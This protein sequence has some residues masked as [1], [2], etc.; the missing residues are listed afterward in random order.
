MS[1]E[2]R[3]WLSFWDKMIKKVDFLNRTTDY[4]FFIALNL[5]SQFLEI[6][7]WGMG[8][9]LTNFVATF[10]FVFTLGILALS[11]C[12]DIDKAKWVQLNGKTLQV[13]KI[14]LLLRNN[15]SPLCCLRLLRLAS[16]VIRDKGMQSMCATCANGFH[17]CSVRWFY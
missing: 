13:L 2:L 16:W 14:S 10:Y 5:L 4:R 9:G 15:L 3:F 17:L 11:F 12:S 7:F 6:S 8:S 1:A